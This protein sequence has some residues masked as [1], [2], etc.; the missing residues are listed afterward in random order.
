MTFSERVKLAMKIVAHTPKTHTNKEPRFLLNSTESSLA[1]VKLT[2]KAAKKSFDLPLSLGPQFSPMLLLAVLMSFESW[3]LVG[4]SPLSIQYLFQSSFSLSP[5]REVKL[6]GEDCINIEAK[7]FTRR[8]A[9]KEMRMKSKF[10]SRA[11][12][13]TS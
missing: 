9:A 12:Y 11:N 13:L 2:R 5:E 10:C 3:L 8:E 1:S 7:R 4:K 6:T